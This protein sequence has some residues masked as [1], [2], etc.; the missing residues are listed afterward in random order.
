M[1]HKVPKLL[2]SQIKSADV[3]STPR[4]RLA[5]AL[6]AAKEL[7]I[8]SIQ[9]VVEMDEGIQ[10]GRIDPKEKVVTRFGKKLYVCI[11]LNP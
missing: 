4:R 11:W 9:H 8:E 5:N 6:N 7:E 3:P 1:A 10:T 2:L